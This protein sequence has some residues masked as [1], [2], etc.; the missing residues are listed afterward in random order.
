MAINKFP[1]L[2]TK[3]TI[4]TINKA[5]EKST[6]KASNHLSKESDVVREN[7]VVHFGM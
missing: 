7:H 5:K 3:T 1:I 6:L 4:A 2:L